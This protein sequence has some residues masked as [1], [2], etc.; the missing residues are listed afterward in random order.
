MRRAPLHHANGTH[1]SF[2]PMTPES[3][4]YHLGRQEERIDHLITR[5]TSLEEAATGRISILRSIPWL[6]IAKGLWGIVLLVVLALVLTGRITI[7]EA[8]MLLGHG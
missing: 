1:T 8:R 2:I 7:T 5:V 4:M 3:I 6:D